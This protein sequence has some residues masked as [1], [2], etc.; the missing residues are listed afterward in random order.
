MTSISSFAATAMGVIP[1]SDPS[2]EA[3]FSNSR[4]ANQF[5]CMISPGWPHEIQKS[6]LCLLPVG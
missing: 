4:S 6:A 5:Y 1:A 2:D 3:G